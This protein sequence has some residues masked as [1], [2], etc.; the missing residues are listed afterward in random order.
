MPPTK[1]TKTTGRTLGAGRALKRAERIFEDLGLTIPLSYEDLEL[2]AWQRQRARVQERPIDVCE[3]HATI[4]KHSATITISSSIAQEG[5]RK[6]VLAHELAHLELHRQA[7]S[8]SLCTPQDLDSYRN[9]DLESQ[10]NEF[11]AELL[12]PSAIAA[13]DCDVRVP[14]FSVVAQ[15]ADKFGTSFTAAALR[16]VDLCPEPL[17]LVATVAGR[18]AWY[19]RGPSF[20][21]FLLG[22]GAQV[23]QDTYAHD[24]FSGKA[25]PSKP[26]N[27]PIEAWCPD[28]H[29]GELDEEA[30]AMP[31][32][33]T[34]LSLLWHRDE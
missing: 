21:L 31:S 23:G 8:A 34:V 26:E 9:N 4:G 16:F 12:M 6:F 11:A 17:G 28:R 2:V 7:G 15:L 25:T 30:F 1:K 10:A 24:A 33:N 32:Y 14:R 29:R 13:P 18:V 22:I 3:G 19:R 5:R 27:V 20:R